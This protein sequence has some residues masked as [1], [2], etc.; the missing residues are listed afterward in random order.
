MERPNG[1]MGLDTF[2]NILEQMADDLFFLLLYHQGEPYLNRNFLNFVRLAKEKNIYCTTSSNGH[3]FTDKFI[4]ETVESG[5]DSMIVSL[6]GV[7]QD[8][9]EKY[10]VNGHVNKVIDG[11]RRF[12]EIKK[13]MKSKTPLIAIQFLVMKQNESQIPQIK[14]LVREI[15]VDRLLIKNIE[16]RSLK[17]AK[18]WLPVNDRYRRYDFD[19]EHYQVKNNNKKSCPRPWLST[20]INWDGSVVPCCFDKNGQ[21][22]MGNINNKN[23]KDIW[24]NKKF[25][26]FR[27]QL[28]TNRKNIDM[29]KN[30]NQGLGSFIPKFLSKNHK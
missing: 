16:V 14:K 17:E 6:D 3:Y 18:E 12:M 23:M 24:E 26:N 25:K 2:K 27:Y 8:I 20:L 13:E 29:C 4:R 22:E 30:C 9:Y 1:K 19:G 28:L 7:T 11:V 10:R 15:G 21:Y 5:L